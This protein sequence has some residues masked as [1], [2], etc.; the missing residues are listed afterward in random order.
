M[1]KEKTNIAENT[2]VDNFFIKNSPKVKKAFKGVKGLK[3]LIL[4][5][6]QVM[7]IDFTQK[8]SKIKAQI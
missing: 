3:V 2:M 7:V 1:P 5:N 6:H 8:K 4:S